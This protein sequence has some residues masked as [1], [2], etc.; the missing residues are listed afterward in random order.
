MHYY[1]FFFNASERLVD[2]GWTAR[3][4]GTL[5]QTFYG[6][7]RRELKCLDD[8]KVYLAENFPVTDEFNVDLVN[9]LKASTISDLKMFF[10]IDAGEFESSCGVD[11]SGDMRT[12][13]SKEYA[14]EIEDTICGCLEDALKRAFDYIT[15]SLGCIEDYYERD[16]RANDMIDAFQMGAQ[17]TWRDQAIELFERY[18]MD[19][20]PDGKEW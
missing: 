7:S 8:A 14:R 2:D 1:E 11:T 18:G 13:S 19:V 9:C 5:D 6:K 15:K 3:W 12:I 20:K 17:A 16:M 10:E 4:D